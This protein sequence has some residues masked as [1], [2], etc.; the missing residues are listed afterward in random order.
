ME[1]KNPD[2]QQQNYP[3]Y[4]SEQIQN[5][6]QLIYPAY[7]N[8]DPP[9]SNLAVF[10]P[11]SM[12]Y[13]AQPLPVYYSNPY[14]YQQQP[15]LGYAPISYI[16][17]PVY[18]NPNQI[19]AEKDRQYDSGCILGG[20]FSCFFGILSTPCMLLQTTRSAQL[21]YLRGMGIMTIIYGIL[22]V[23]ITLA[24]LQTTQISVCNYSQMNSSFDSC[25]TQNESNPAFIPCLIVGIAYSAAGVGIYMHARNAFKTIRNDPLIAP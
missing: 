23:I 16:P 13:P 20:C 10:Q 14:S 6:N 19:S 12:I 17:Q 2:Q 24:F 3:A 11:Q 15:I 18:N 8:L 25:H 7:A 9:S 1:S 22:F 5:Q 4:S 21:G